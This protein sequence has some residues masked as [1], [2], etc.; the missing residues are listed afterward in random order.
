[1]ASHSRFHFGPGVKTMWLIASLKIRKRIP[2]PRDRPMHN[3]S[4]RRQ[5]RESSNIRLHYLLG[6]QIEDVLV[7][8]N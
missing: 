4:V 8:I 7:K 5:M 1:M 6:E 3:A 2:R